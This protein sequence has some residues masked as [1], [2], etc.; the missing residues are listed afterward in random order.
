MVIERRTVSIK[1]DYLILISKVN[2]ATGILFTPSVFQQGSTV[3]W[4]TVCD[5][6]VI[7]I[8]YGCNRV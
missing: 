7:A 1:F 8:C 3:M 2:V 5:N 4:Q 6:V